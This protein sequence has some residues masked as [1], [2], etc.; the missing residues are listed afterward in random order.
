MRA[1]H[2]CAPAASL[3]AAQFF[4]KAHLYPRVRRLKEQLADTSPRSLTGAG[5][6]R[7]SVTQAVLLPYRHDLGRGEP[8]SSMGSCV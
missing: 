5:S 1:G 8:T 2:S 3:H 6:I 7:A 4:P